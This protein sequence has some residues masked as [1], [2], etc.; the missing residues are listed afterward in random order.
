MNLQPINKNV[1]QDDLE[2]IFQNIIKLEEALKD[3]IKKIVQF[4]QKNGGLTKLSHYIMS[5]VN[6]AISLNRGFLTLN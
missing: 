2:G 6:R 1:T 3:E 5:V 4:E